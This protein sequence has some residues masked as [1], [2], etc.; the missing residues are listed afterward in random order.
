[1]DEKKRTTVKTVACRDCALRA[2]SCFVSFTEAEVAFMEKFKSGELHI[3]RGTPILSQG[4]SS[5]H[6]FTVLEG[7]AT[8]SVT[9]EDGR[10]QVI[11]FVFPGD[12]VGLQAAVL[13][14]MQHS[15]T[16]V[17]PMHLCV[18]NRK[19]FF[20]LF[21]QQ[22]QRGYDVSWLAA[23]EEYFLGDYLLSVGRRTALERVA[24]ALHSLHSRAHD[25]GL[26][27]EDGM[28]MPFTQQDLAD[29]IGLSL[30]HTNKTL[31]RLREMQVASW[32]GKRLEIRDLD[33]LLEIAGVE[34]G[35]P[36]LRPLI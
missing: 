4:A 13:N 35:P 33:R 3:Q 15:V 29:A 31:A 21:T 27:T 1:L 28:D 34:I 6:L 24:F 7:S 16:A 8:R 23:R 25:V 22:P 9:L 12:F 2:R 14:E 36:R 26:A 19:D 20:L 18:F 32:K 30:V 11:G 17:T 5:P 10:R